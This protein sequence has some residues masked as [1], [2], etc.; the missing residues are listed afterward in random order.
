MIN[1]GKNT[2]I[3]QEKVKSEISSILNSDR[4][5]HAYLIAGPAGIGK[6]ALALSFAEAVNGI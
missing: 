1:I 6:K 2:I 3:G 4:L 5:G